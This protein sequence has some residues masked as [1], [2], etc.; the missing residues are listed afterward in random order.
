M[1][2][3]SFTKD[4]LAEENI[5][6]FE[7][8]EERQKIFD[9][10]LFNVSEQTGMPLSFFIEEEKKSDVM[11]RMGEANSTTGIIE[12]MIVE[13]GISVYDAALWQMVVGLDSNPKI[14][15]ISKIPT[16]IYWKGSLGDL[17]NIRAGGFTRQSFVYD[18]DDLSRVSSDLSDKGK[19]GFLFRIMN[20]KGKY[21]ATD[22]LDGKK[23]FKDFPN[24][25]TLH[26][27]DWKPIAGENAWVV[28]SSLHSYHKKYFDSKKG[29]Y[30]HNHQATEILLAQELARAAMILQADNGGVRMAP[31]G[32]Y[33]YSLERSEGISLNDF[34]RK[35]DQGGQKSQKDFNAI[36]DQ[37]G[38]QKAILSAPQSTWYYFEQSTENNLSW[39][40]AFR[41]LY[42][43]TGAS[44][45]YDAMLKVENY[46]KSAW[47]DKENYFYQGM[48]FVDGQWVANKKHFATDVQT[49]G[50]SKLSPEKIDSWFG[51]GTAYKMWLKTKQIAGFI[52]GGKVLGVGY[53]AEKD[54]ISIEWSV[55]ALYAMRE[56]AHHYKRTNILW[57]QNA[58]KDAQSIR[59]ALETYK[60]ELD[61]GLAAYPYSGKRNWIPFGWFSHD[62]QVLSLVSTCWIYLY[63]KKY[64]PFY[65]DS[66]RDYLFEEI[67][68][69]N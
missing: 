10:I 43:M 12:R 44:Q 3:V 30:N 41:F 17:D 66:K 8:Y 2:T 59:D 15:E 18:A 32:T 38:H 21:L 19:R 28:I 47:N 36:I 65:I 45:Y 40:T 60:V 26:W 53:T 11:Q 55:G 58:L 52:Q 22:P 64:N 35:L 54:R 27:E 48:H 25:S 46:L 4:I 56:L 20:A 68:F 16:D 14:F 69:E 29:Q 33:F 39:Y 62:P 57:A 6:L 13:E 23:S 9:W 61:N 49:W 42:E 37:I 7:E 51:E 34:M 1:C 63:D 67:I 24:W 5:S 31:M 50:I